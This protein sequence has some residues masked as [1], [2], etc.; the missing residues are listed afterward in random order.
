LRE[1]LGDAVRSVVLENV[2][3]TKATDQLSLDPSDR[4]AFVAMLL[5]ELQS[6][7]TFNCARYRLSLRKTE[8]WI[9]KGRPM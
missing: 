8:E 1:Q 2:P 9:G 6:L 7:E 5:R 3:A 4:D